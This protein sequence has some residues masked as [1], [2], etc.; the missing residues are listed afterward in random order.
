MENVGREGLG[1]TYR[2]AAPRAVALRVLARILREMGEEDT[3]GSALARLFDS[4]ASGQ[5]AS[6]GDLVGRPRPGGWSFTR[7][8]RR[9]T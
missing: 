9:K 5:P 6:I 1:L 8:P 2:P 7:A 4:L 3:R